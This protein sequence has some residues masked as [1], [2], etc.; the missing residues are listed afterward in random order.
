MSNHRDD[1]QL[2]AS[3]NIPFHHISVT[4]DTKAQAEAKLL[5]IVEQEEI[6]LVVLARYMQVLSDGL[7]RA[8]AGRAITSTIPSCPASR[9]PSPTRRRRSAA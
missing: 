8:L 3:Y 7:C 5:D 9:A 4:A 6:E 2:A 1:Y